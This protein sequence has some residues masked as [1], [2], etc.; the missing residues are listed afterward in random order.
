MD[1]LIVGSGLTGATIARLLTDRGKKCLVVEKRA[2]LGGNVYD[3]EHPSGIRFHT[4]GP[5]YFRTSSSRIWDFVQRFADF[6]PFEARVQSWVQGV[7]RT[8]PRRRGF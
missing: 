2:H 6:Y 8:G 3:E 4:Y 1:F 5:H 7:T